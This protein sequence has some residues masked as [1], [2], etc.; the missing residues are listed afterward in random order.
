VNFKEGGGVM[1]K[2]PR[3]VFAAAI[4]LFGTFFCATYIKRR[5]ETSENAN[6]PKDVCVAASDILPNRPIDEHGVRRIQMP[7]K[8]VQP[9]A[10]NDCQQAVGRIAAIPL[11]SGTQL[12]GAALVDPGQAGLSTIVDVTQLAL[13]VSVDGINGVGGLIRPGNLVDIFL[14]VT[15]LPSASNQAAGRVASTEERTEVRLLWQKVPVLAVGQEY[16]N[17]RPESSA[18]EGPRTAIDPMPGPLAPKL[19]EARHV[20]LMVTPDQAQGLILAQR[21]GHVTLA[22]RSNLDDTSIALGALN[23]H[24]LIGSQTP[25]KPRDTYNEY[26]GLGVGPF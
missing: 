1:Q 17:L 21:I 9:L 3:L 2:W 4:G 10:L 24:D 6:V 16:E 18:P 25:I 5:V 22:L 11:A 19:G 23:A 8:Y 13:T 14:A 26:H 7:L 12:F 15:T 20:T